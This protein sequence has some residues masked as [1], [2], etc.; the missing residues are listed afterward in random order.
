MKAR[1][2]YGVKLPAAYENKENSDFNRYQR[3]HA[4]A[5]EGSGLFFTT[6]LLSALATPLFSA[7]A[8]AVFIIGRYFY[9][10]GYYQ[11]T[12]S[13]RKGAV[14]RKYSDLQSID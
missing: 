13:R 5:I 6:L 8:G 1:K 4:N 10:V 11:S 3:V 2:K 14:Y 9:A 7:I 12:E